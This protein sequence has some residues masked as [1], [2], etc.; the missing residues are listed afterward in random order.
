MKAN[1]SFYKNVK[2]LEK[3]LNE[4]HFITQELG[5]DFYQRKTKYRKKPKAQVS[6]GEF[7]KSFS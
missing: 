7:S 2:I 5:D 1:L 6:S 3:K 4:L